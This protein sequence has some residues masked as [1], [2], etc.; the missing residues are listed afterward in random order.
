M[1]KDR[2]R[3]GIVGASGYTGMELLRLLL[4]HPQ[5]EVACVTSRTEAGQP[6]ATSFPHLQG[7]LELNFC[8]P[9]AKVLS[10][11]DLVF[12]TTPNATA[13]HMVPELL[14]T[15]VRVI[16]LSADF[17]IQDATLWSQWY[18]EAHACPELLP[19][20]V[21]GLP[22]INRASISEARLVAN[23]GCYPTAVVLALL[24]V[25]E[26]GAVDP[27]RLI[28]DAKSGVSGAGRKASL[29]TLF[30]EVS[31]NFKAYGVSGHRHHP[32]IRQALG[33]V[34]AS[35]DPELTFV[36][37]LLPMIRG[38]HATVYAELTDSSVDVQRLYEQ[39]YQDEPF[40]QIMAPD[41]H[42]DT[43][44]VRGSNICRLA[45]H[46]SDGCRLIVLSVID[47]L[48]KGAAGQAVQNMNLMYHW[49]ETTGLG[50]MPLVP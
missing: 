35:S 21:Y 33:W 45:L 9:E 18:G 17:R 4:Q 34:T 28:A 23:P 39:R 47:N 40:V 30:G 1:S 15:G 2:I 14:N 13:M 8:A 42:P 25:L 37:H 26:A 12:F 44:S 16:D 43:R 31:E 19:E 32:E 38:I 24:P 22:E 46:R 7:V 36:P 11:C 29:A 50:Q 6:V 10:G 49:S 5:V 20:A 27:R 41:S 3:V 48:V